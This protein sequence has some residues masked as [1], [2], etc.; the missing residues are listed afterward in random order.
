MQIDLINRDLGKNCITETNAV[1]ESVKYDDDYLEIIEEIRKLDALE[2][3]VEVDFEKIIKLSLEILEKKSKDMII[4]I[5]L[6]YSILKIE[7]IN[8][9]EKSIQILKDMFENYSK[10]LFPKNKIA[11]F[12]AFFWWMKKILLL[13]KDSENI[14]YTTILEDDMYANLFNNISFLENYIN[15]N[16]EQRISFV[17]LLECLNTKLGSHKITKVVER[18][19]SPSLSL[20]NTH[21]EN[22]MH[23]ASSETEVNSIV[24]D[25]I[26]NLSF[27]ETFEFVLK[28]LDTLSST[29]IKTNDYN[30][31]LF[32]INRIKI[33]FT[34]TE[35]P[36]NES[37][38]TYLKP[39]E[40]HEIEYLDKLYKEK[41]WDELLHE[42][43]SR[44]FRFLFWFD[45]HHY[46]YICLKNKEIDNLEVYSDFMRNFMYQFPKLVTMKFENGFAFSNSIT[47]VW[48]N[49]IL[50]KP[51][52]IKDKS[53]EKDHLRKGYELISQDKIIQAIKFFVNESKKSM[54]KKQEV[55]IIMELVAVL[56][57]YKYD[58]LTFN[59]LDF[60]L[61]VSITYKLHEWDPEI[62]IKIYKLLLE[63]HDTIEYKIDVEKLNDIKLNLSL[64]DLELYLSLTR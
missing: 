31:Y 37:G 26:S 21:E 45:L 16:Y 47:M 61:E 2:F 54:N 28:D 8:G 18:N 51:D 25:K 12:N 10:D 49:N 41:N 43:E 48:I 19:V 62:A 63:A 9:F 6:S 23:S 58:D 34:M 15:S 44:I 5:Y 4:A 30:I 35:L 20:N 22:I 56:K 7:G 14:E 39:P 57:N 3:D 42:A 55:E 53:V 11:Q 1:G 33:W 32:L 64:L 52:I 59:Y 24:S 38:K 60:L 27:Y 46:V 29:L 13:F 40:E 17:E 36:K 50:K